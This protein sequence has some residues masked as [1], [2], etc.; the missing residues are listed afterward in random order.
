MQIILSC[1]CT[2]QNEYII[3]QYA[4]CQHPIYEIVFIFLGQSQ[5]KTKLKSLL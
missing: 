4:T 2:L 1:I 5:I 3:Y